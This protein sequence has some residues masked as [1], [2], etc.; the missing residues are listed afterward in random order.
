MLRSSLAACLVAS[1]VICAAN[2]NLSAQ[3]TTRTVA[4]GKPS[5]EQYLSPASP[6]E[7]TAARKA[8]RIAWMTY[9]RG[10]RNVY[11]AAAPSFH[12]VRLTRFLDD[13][14][15]DLTD[16]KLSDDGSIAVF[17]R[18]SAPNR[19]G[20]VAN[21]SH[22]PSGAEREIWAVR[23][24]GGAPW[25]VAE[26]AA[27][28]LSPDGRYVLYVKDDQI[29][30]GRV[31]ASAAPDSM[32]RGQKPFIKAWGR[33]RDPRWSPD[34]SKI[35]FVSDRGN[36]AFIAV[37]DGKTRSM[38]YLAPGVDFDGAPVWS[39]DGKRVAFTRRPG[40]PFGQ[41]SQEGRGGLGNPPGPAGSGASPRNV[42]PPGLANPFAPGGGA[43][44]ARTDSEPERPL[45][46][47]LCR[48]TFAGGH[49]LAIM[50]ADVSTQSARELWHN[51]PNDSTF[52]AIQRLLWAGDHILFPVSP[53]NDEWERYYSLDANAGTAKPVLLT[54]T[55]G[56]IE[57][58]TSAAVSADGKTFY[59][60]TNA[61]D[62]ERRHIWSVPTSGGTPRRIS[63][64]D[65][66]ETWPQPLASG[67]Q[68]AVLYFDASTPASV[69]LVPVDGGK[70]R[71]IFPTLGAD[72][73]KSEHVTPEVITVKSPDGLEIHNQLFL[74]TDLRAGERRPAIIFVHGGPVR[75]MLPAYH[76]MQFYH[77]AYAVNQWLA[78][79]GYVVLSVNYRSGIGY[80]RSFRQAQNTNARG[81]SEYQDVLAAGKY[82]QTRADVDP[83]RIGI[84]GLS[85]GG[86][87]TSQALARNSDLF[88]AGADLAGVHLYGSS[89]DTTSVSYKSSAISAID[90]WK[91]PVFLVHGDDDRNVDFAQTVGLVQ[92]LRAR[93]IYYELQVI[94]DDLHESMLHRNWVRTFSHMGDFFHRFVWNKEAAAAT[95]GGKR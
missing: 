63:T 9:D 23:T 18:G 31:V 94:P 2:A 59:Y 14:G 12:P 78:N 82:L 43:G 92:L 44:R 22:D 88:V 8:D 84:W 20:W 17:V 66:I 38:T 69:G 81:N 27:P 65:G 62:I 91:S 34:G 46:P 6:L 95:D 16:V 72:F 71:V 83:T 36:H 89:L 7:M 87:L 33:Q 79:Q 10:M 51:A 52:P 53:L 93:G 42:C 49:T 48:A 61:S 64:G 54:T 37:Y 11:T 57:D 50:V 13:D 21:P 19:Q 67:K 32:D 3:A 60:C 39:P 76:Y 86:L 85:Y 75:Q 35:A 68:L 40:T 80:G 26:G 55:N 77:W 30:R 58:A 25:R 47:G 45:I 56:L 74:P 29:Y 24:S 15:R 4:Q 5:I 41:Q 90:S 1:L 70:A 73:P 28:A